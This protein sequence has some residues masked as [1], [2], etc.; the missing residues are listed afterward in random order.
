MQRIIEMAQLGKVPA[1]KPDDPSSSLRTLGRRES[2]PASCLLTCWHTHIHTYKY[3][4]T[5]RHLHVHAH[6]NTHPKQISFILK[7]KEGAE[8]MAQGS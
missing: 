7:K 8:E 3:T 5:H 1:D 2:T 6:I 4:H